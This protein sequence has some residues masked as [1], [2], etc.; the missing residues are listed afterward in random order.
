[1]RIEGDLVLGQGQ[2]LLLRAAGA[3]DRL[4]AVDHHDLDRRVGR[5]ALQR[6]AQPAD[7]RAGEGVASLAIGHLDDGDRIAASVEVHSVCHGKRGSRTKR[8]V[9]AAVFFR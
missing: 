8:R 1:V 9:P 5:D 7:Q 4:V 6:H 3:E 2:Q